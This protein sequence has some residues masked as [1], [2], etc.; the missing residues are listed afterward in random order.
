[1]KGLSGRASLPPD[2]GM[3]F[4]YEDKDIPEFWMKD[5]LFPLDIIWI[6][7]GV[8]IDIHENVPP[9]NPNTPDNQL[10]LYSPKQPITMVLEVNAGV[11]KTLGG[12][13]ALLNQKI[14][15]QNI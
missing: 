8:I 10:E 7:D 2:Y 3:I 15:L 12:K 1:M 6:D 14:T 4:L 11:V 5:V 13:N 9:P